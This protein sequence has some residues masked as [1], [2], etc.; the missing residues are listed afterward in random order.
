MNF[1]IAW[2]ITKSFLK[3]A[4]NKCRGTPELTEPIALPVHWFR[5]LVEFL[6]LPILNAEFGLGAVAVM[7]VFFL[8]QQW[9]VVLESSFNAEVS[10]ACAAYAS[11]SITRAEWLGDLRRQQNLLMWLALTLVVTVI[12]FGELATK[13]FWGSEVK[14]ADSTIFFRFIP[15]L[16]RAYIFWIGKSNLSR[17]TAV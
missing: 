3:A 7:G 14:G 2:Q 1:L 16:D 10:R 17:T 13:V 12:V 8:M 6:A 11:L 5:L 15:L 4:N 9:F